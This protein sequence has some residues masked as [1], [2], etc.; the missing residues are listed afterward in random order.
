[1]LIPGPGGYGEPDSVLGQGK[2][3]HTHAHAH[4]C[5]HTQ[6]CTLTHGKGSL[7]LGKKL[8][9]FQVGSYTGEE[10]EEYG[11]RINWFNTK[12]SHVDMQ[13]WGW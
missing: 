7:H 4:T 9:W 8:K 11:N 1:M 10:K 6:A 5:V 3:H 13:N 2:S 12:Y